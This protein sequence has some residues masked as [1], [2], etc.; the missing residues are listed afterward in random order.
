MTI[1]I[2]DAIINLIDY[3]NINSKS[4]K[5]NCKNYF[6]EEVVAA[7]RIVTWPTETEMVMG[8]VEDVSHFVG[9]FPWMMLSHLLLL[10]SRFTT[11]QILM[12][13]TKIWVSMAKK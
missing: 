9:T 11:C 6:A 2:L 7:V 1:A 5:T 13:L 10:V 4:K 12:L 8:V 3:C